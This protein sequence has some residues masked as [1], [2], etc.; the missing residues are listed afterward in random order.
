MG[1]S[2]EDRLFA[3][4]RNLREYGN[5]KK[6][7]E[8]AAKILLKYH[9]EAGLPRCRELVCHF[10][11]MYDRLAAIIDGHREEGLAL[12]GENRL[13]ELVLRM[14]EPSAVERFAE[15]LDTRQLL[16]DMANFLVDW[17][18]VR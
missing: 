6:S 18:L 1:L 12:Y 16:L 13:G 3:V 4:I 5:Y 14:L 15:R 11:E 8:N 9:P 7:D 10:G 2:M 17:R